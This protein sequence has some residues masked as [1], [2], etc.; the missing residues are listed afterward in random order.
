VRKKSARTYVD[1]HACRER[2]PWR[3]EPTVGPERHG[4]VPYKKSTAKST[5]SASSWVANPCR[6]GSAYCELPAKSSGGILPTA[7]AREL[8]QEFRRGVVDHQH[9]TLGPRIG[10]RSYDAHDL[11][12]AVRLLSWRAPLVLGVQGY[13]TQSGG[14]RCGDGRNA[15][16]QA[17]RGCRQATGVRFGCAAL[18]PWPWLRSESWLRWHGLAERRHAGRHQEAALPRSVARQTELRRRR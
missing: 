8:P 18:G 13:C 11:A 12:P 10:Q 2:P 4:G 6:L 3:S 15:D 7:V 9:A 17:I 5:A 14:G 16:R 1:L